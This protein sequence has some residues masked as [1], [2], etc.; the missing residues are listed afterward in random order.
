MSD[1]DRESL[2]SVEILVADFRLFSLSNFQFTNLR[3]LQSLAA[4]NMNFYNIFVL[5]VSGF[6]LRIFC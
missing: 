4:G 2:Q 3:W 1:K 5:D 6:E